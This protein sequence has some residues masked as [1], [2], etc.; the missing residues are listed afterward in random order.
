MTLLTYEEMTKTYM[1]DKGGLKALTKNS[2]YYEN[3]L[4]YM[5]PKVIQAGGYTG[6]AIAIGT[7]E[8]KE[9]FNK[10]IEKLKQQ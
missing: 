2:L 1:A 7:R 4:N 5:L 9:L 3:V 10:M 6:S 8:N